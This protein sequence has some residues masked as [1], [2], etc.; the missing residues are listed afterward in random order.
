MTP[1]RL[2]ART[3]LL[4][5][6]PLVSGGRLE[7][8]QIQFSG[9]VSAMQMRAHSRLPAPVVR[10]A[11]SAAGFG[12]EADVSRGRLGFTVTYLQS[13]L[14]PRTAGAPARNA[15]EGEFLLNA[16]ALPWLN[17]GAG[18][19]SRSYR[20]TLGRQRWAMWELRARVE[21]ATLPG[22]GQGYFTV[23]PVLA[24][25]VNVPEGWRSGFGSE[26]GFTL[27]PFPAPVWLRLA[28]RVEY[29]RLEDRRS[30]LTDGLRVT[31]GMSLGR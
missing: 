18:F 23:W 1:G 5:L 17:L 26:A 22:N 9:A 15:A 27:S 30:E 21:T 13:K 8:Q 24:A 20:T 31:A 14:S 6:L 19:H 28:Y 12:L 29:F 4:I 2:T 3:V 16:D 7:A 10:E 25:S 11:L